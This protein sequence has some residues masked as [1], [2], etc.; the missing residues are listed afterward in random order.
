MSN[1]EGAYDQTPL[2]C[3]R[4]VDMLFWGTVLPLLYF[5]LQNYCTV[6][7]FKCCLCIVA[8]AVQNYCIVSDFKCCLCQEHKHGAFKTGHALLITRLTHPM[9]LQHQ[10]VKT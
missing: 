7:D 2:Q 10:L 5:M 1:L 3:Q 4:R 6:S 9:V 8:P